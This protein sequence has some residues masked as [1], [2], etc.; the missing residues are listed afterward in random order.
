[1]KERERERTTPGALT[2]NEAVAHLA[3]DQNLESVR[4]DVALE[5]GRMGHVP[6]ILEF[7]WNLVKPKADA[8]IDLDVLL[9]SRI[10]ITG[11]CNNVAT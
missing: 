8:A 9:A 6:A 7:L 1:M 5:K 11:A 10:K 2:Q 3:T 4:C